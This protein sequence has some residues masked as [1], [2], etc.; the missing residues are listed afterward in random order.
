MV[1][2]RLITGSFL[3]VS[4]SGCVSYQTKPLVPKAIFREIE[5]SR[6]TLFKS[7][8]EAFTFP[9]AIE[10]MNQSSP[11]LAEVRSEYEKFNSIAKT[12]TPWPNPSVELGPD[13]G[14]NL[15]AGATNKTQ[16]FVGLGFT[17]PLGGKLKKNDDLNIAIA[18]RA[19]VE[20]QG[21]H[22]ELYLDLR[23]SFT[24]RYIASRKQEIQQV[25]VYSSK[26]AIEVADSLMKAGGSTALDRA[27][28]VLEGQKAELELFDLNNELNESQSSL[29]ILLGLDASKF[30]KINKNS[31]PKIV[32]SIPQFNKLK[33]ILI[34]N[35]INL[36]RLRYDYE[37]AEKSL[38]LEISKQ[39]PDI[40]FGTERERE[41]GGKSTTLGL[42]LGIEIPFFDRNHQGI[43]EASKEREHIRKKYTT[44]VHKAL[45]NLEK[46]YKITETNIKRYEF[47]T[48]TVVKSANENLKIAKQS[49]ESGGIKVLQYLD[50]LRTY[51][52]IMKDTTTIESEVRMSWINLERVLGYPITQFPNERD[53][54]ISLH[55][56]SNSNIQ[57]N[58][59][60]K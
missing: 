51:Q 10:I 13:I 37:I 44:A 41:V 16:P 19:F 31:M 14:S 17:I 11:E 45:S 25:L 3:I 46:N 32:K 35:H 15:G 58:S 6:Q 39:Y 30:G 60:A 2:I 7:E 54:S 27:M 22:R 59:N 43:V 56:Q 29:S 5:R 24:K 20:T 9:K 53:F 55:P 36:V 4:I 33:S 18:Q 42:R 38:R 12:K 1:N 40:Q 34:N 26:K 23:E 28:I 47:I 52:E 48:N 8:S 21:K 49:M 50:V 57:E